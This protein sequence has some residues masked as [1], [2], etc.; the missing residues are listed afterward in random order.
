[1]EVMRRWVE[2]GNIMWHHYG[3]SNDGQSLLDGHDKH[4]CCS[5]INNDPCNLRGHA[6]LNI[7]QNNA[8][9][10]KEIAFNKMLRN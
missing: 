5:I 10:G 8:Q 4:R 3:Y 7:K 6:L 9:S 1:M 2:D